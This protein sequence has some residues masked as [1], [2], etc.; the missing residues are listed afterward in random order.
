MNNRRRNRLALW[1]TAASVLVA[2]QAFGQLPDIAPL[3]TRDPLTQAEKDTIRQWLDQQVKR[4]V[5]INSPQEAQRFQRELIKPLQ[6]EPPASVEFRTVFIE[7]AADVSIPLLEKGN[8]VGPFMLV[9]TLV[10]FDHTA[11][12]KALVA[13]LASTIPAVRYWSANGL[14]KLAAR[15]ENEGQGAVIPTIDALQ[16][17]GQRESSPVV[18]RK[19]Y[20]ALRFGSSATQCAQAAASILDNRV[21][22]YQAPLPN[23]PAA[24]LEGFA[25]IARMSDPSP[26]VV[27]LCGQSVAKVLKLACE[28]YLLQ[29]AQPAEQ[30]QQ[31]L[32]DEL[33][34]V[35]QQGESVLKRLCQQANVTD[36][37]PD[38]TGPM[39]R[40]DADGMQQAMAEWFGQ[41]NPR[42]E[43]IMN[44]SPFSMPVGLDVQLT[45][46][47]GAAADAG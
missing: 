11:T 38:I 21:A 26:N 47:E 24:D 33:A 18:L 31:P 20:Q 27:R 43:G 13:G 30:R 10:E 12:R 36:R 14:G 1:G 19:I 37:L 46:A 4:M 6:D 40:D 28:V 8:A 7:Q 29:L 45:P 42:Q 5:S 32:I 15:I 9:K 25:V 39:T 23:S 22:S 35:I 17:A 34:A 44:R 3:R 16:Q 2:V 41:A